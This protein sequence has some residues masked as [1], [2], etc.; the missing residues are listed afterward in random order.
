M[1]TLKEHFNYLRR[2]E[3]A[4]ETEEGKELEPIGKIDVDYVVR[5]AS[6]P[7]NLSLYWGGASLN[8][9]EPASSPSTYLSEL[10]LE[11]YSI[12]CYLVDNDK[13][14][15]ILLN[16]LDV[17]QL[18]KGEVNC[19]Y[20]GESSLVNLMSY[21]YHYIPDY[22]FRNNS[23]LVRRILNDIKETEVP[24][25]HTTARRFASQGPKKG[26]TYTNLGHYD[27]TLPSSLFASQGPKKSPTA[28]RSLWLPPALKGGKAKLK[29]RGNRKTFKKNKRINRRTN[30]K[31]VKQKCKRNIARSL[32]KG[33]GNQPRDSVKTTHTK[34]KSLR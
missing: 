30:C 22:S 17:I 20:D 21:Y 19:L 12:L 1:D 11:I 33:M 14:T 10:S 9:T 31:K 23:E 29:L 2:A 4:E 27:D 16:E 8:V 25:L 6:R 13:D 34:R 7:T 32:K 24:I 3:E 18:Y 28:R 15:Y 5:T 26:A